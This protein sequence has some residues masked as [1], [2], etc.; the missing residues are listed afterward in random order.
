M[1]VVGHDPGNA[2]RARQGDEL[3]DE[4]LLLGKAVIPALDG[5]ASVEE[6]EQRGHGFAGAVRIPGGEPLWHPAGRATGEREEAASMAG[7]GVERDGGISTRRVHAPPRDERAQVSIAFARLG[8]DDE[9]RAVVA[10]HH[11]QLGAEDAA[12]V[13]LARG[14]GEPDRATEVV[15]VGQ[16]EGRHA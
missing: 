2:E 9:V 14:L 12:N 13:K 4:C 8:Q 15:M 11:R 16:G 6:I 10:G 1:H 5:Q 7:Q 3:P